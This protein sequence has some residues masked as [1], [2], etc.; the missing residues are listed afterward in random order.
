MSAE[1]ISR[2]EVTR[3]SNFGKLHAYQKAGEK[4]KKVWITHF[5]ERTC[6]ICKRLDGQEVDLNANFSE[7]TS[8][9]EGLAPP[10]HVRCRCGWSFKPSEE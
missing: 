3:A 8:G 1:M 4:G 7:K 6:E 2:T 5:D 9:W 10:A